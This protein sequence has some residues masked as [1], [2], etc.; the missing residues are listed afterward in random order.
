MDVISVYE[1]VGT[2]SNPAASPTTGTQPM[3]M[4]GPYDVTTLEALPA[5]AAKDTN[6]MKNHIP[7]PMETVSRNGHGHSQRASARV[8][9]RARA[10]A[11]R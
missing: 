7:P 4:A 2:S 1:P 11:A 3:I 5:P 10:K 9:Q 8:P 6:E